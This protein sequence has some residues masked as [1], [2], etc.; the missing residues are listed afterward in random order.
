MFEE[1]IRLSRRFLKIKNSPYRR[2]LIR[3]TDF[4]HRMTIIVGQR[5]V[6]KTTTLVQHLL[7]C[8]NGDL[9]DP[10]ILYLQV[11]HFQMGLASMYEI[12]EQ[13]CLHGGQWIAFDEIHKYPDWSKELKSI[14]DTFPEL[15]ILAS[16][17]SAL[18]IY[19]GSHDLTR[20]A[21]K[22]QMQGLSFR[23][24]LELTHQIDF[25]W[26]SLEDICGSHEKIT[27]KI[28]DRLEGI[29]KKV[30][31]EFKHY[32]KSGYYPYF[33]ELKNEAN[34]LLTLEQNLH[35]TIESDLS[36]IHP[37]LS[38]NS[39]AKIKQLLIFVA[40]SVP[41]IPNWN[42]IRLALDIGDLRTLKSYFQH[43]ED[44][45]LI[46]SVSRGTKKLSQIESPSKVYMDNP[47]QLF[48]IAS[49]QPEKGTIRET[50]FLNTLSQNHH[51]RLPKNGDF[52]VDDLYYFEVGGRKKTF[53]Q[54]KTENNAFLAC[55]D[56]EFGV[57]NKI[58]LWL[59]GFLY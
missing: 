7:D 8:V 15:N 37:Q 46:R 2:Y 50:Y 32:L 25:P 13:F 30:L 55:D 6:G 26:Y 27:T 9:L 12:A 33:S 3:T 10:R 54:V 18:E 41:F 57:G 1:L 4:D 44:A 53:H 48:A 29:H 58:P 39:L 40:N 28:I 31:L 21:V 11:D 43:L 38:G 24:Y 16:G 47:N 34:Y 20:R 5:G 35:T 51:I 52:C 22:Y 42:K 36:S 56:L 23:E 49:E 59:F 19:R 17:S 45:C 14:Y